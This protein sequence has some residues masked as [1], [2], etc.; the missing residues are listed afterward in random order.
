M[1]KIVSI[2]SIL[3]VALAAGF[4]Y[5]VG[6]KLANLQTPTEPEEPSL[7]NPEQEE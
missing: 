5:L 3:L 6:F 1:G 2:V 7:E 4:I